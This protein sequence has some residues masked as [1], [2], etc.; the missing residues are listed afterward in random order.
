MI[1]YKVWVGCLACYNE[2]RLTGE[3]FDAAEAPQDMEAFEDAVSHGT[4]DWMAPHEELWVFDHENSP[5]DG[6]YAP[7]DAVRYAEWLSDLEDGGMEPFMAYLKD[8][9]EFTES[10]VSDFQDAYMGRYGSLSDYLWEMHEGMELPAW[11][12][13]HRGAIIDGIAHDVRCGGEVTELQAPELDVYI[14]AN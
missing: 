7:M 5:V 14:F 12:E 3:W 9:G 11:A 2:G 6:E 4:Q 1:D 13:P 8:Q 10:S